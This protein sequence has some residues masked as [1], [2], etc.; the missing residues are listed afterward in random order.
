MV[1]GAGLAV[2]F[3][4]GTGC[5]LFLFSFV[6]YSLSYFYVSDDDGSEEE[7]DYFFFFVNP[8]D[9]SLF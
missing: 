7:S 6:V 9:F 5:L 3:E 8:L 2:V 4:F 1:V